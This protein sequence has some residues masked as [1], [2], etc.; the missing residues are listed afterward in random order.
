MSRL[1]IVQYRNKLMYYTRLQEKE[2][3]EVCL[4]GVKL[5]YCYA[6]QDS[7][8]TTS[9]PR[10]LMNHLQRTEKTLYYNL[11]TNYRYRKPQGR[12]PTNLP[13]WHLCSQTR[14]PSYL[15]LHLTTLLVKSLSA[16]S[17]LGFM[18][19]LVVKKQNRVWITYWFVWITEEKPVKT[20]NTWLLYPLC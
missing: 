5:F 17:K 20:C 11:F 12:R 4:W 13:K 3:P 6:V 15:Q 8:Q 14:L 7:V 19:T 18:I 1:G 10:H 2:H 16:T 9:L